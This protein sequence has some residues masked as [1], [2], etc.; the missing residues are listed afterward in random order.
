MNEKNLPSPADI[1]RL[2]SET[3]EHRR[4]LGLEPTAE[5]ADPAVKIGWWQRFWG[6]DFRRG[7]EPG[8]ISM[9]AA[10]GPR[11]LRNAKLLDVNGRRRYRCCDSIDLRLQHDIGAGSRNSGGKNAAP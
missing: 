4:R 10:D 11:F 8:E 6:P 3:P 7:A 2:G 1:E 5:V 9:D